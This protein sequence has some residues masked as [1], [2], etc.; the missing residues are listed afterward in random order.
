MKLFNFTNNIQVLS[1]MYLWL[2][3]ISIVSCQHKENTQ[4]TH[5]DTTQKIQFKDYPDLKLGFTTQNFLQVMPVTVENSKHLI[6]YAAAQGYAW[7]ELRDPDATLTQQESK[8]IA[9]YAKQKGIEVIYAIQKGLLDEDFWSSFQNGV[10]NAVVFSGPQ[11]IRSLAS[12]AEITQNENKIGWTQ[13]ELALV[14]Q[15]ADSAAAIAQAHGLQYVIENGQETFFG[16]GGDSYGIADAFSRVSNKVGWQF[17]TANPFSVSRMHASPDRVK[18][19]LQEHADNLYYIHLKSAQHGAAQP[20][21]TDNPLNLEEVFKIL[22]AHQISYVAIELQ[23]V[24]DREQAF[25]NMEQSIA[26]LQSQNLIIIP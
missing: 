21:L 2:I 20:V 7:I 15:Y 14:V 1:G 19:F 11:V 26:Y 5:A 9:D 22:S 16:A 23:A 4:A 24:D 13:E 10:K 8:E 12:G 18:A 25:A 6:D 17:D 3:A